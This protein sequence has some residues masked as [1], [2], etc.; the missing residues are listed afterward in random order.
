MENEK[1]IHTYFLFLILL[2]KQIIMQVSCFFQI[3]FA[4]HFSS[5]L[6][7]EEANDIKQNV[8]L[9][10]TNTTQEQ[11]VAEPLVRYRRQP[12]RPIVKY[13]SRPKRFKIKRIKRPKIKYSFAEP[14]TTYYVRKPIVFKKPT[15]ESSIYEDFSHMNVE[16]ADFDLPPSSYEAQSMELNLYKHYEPTQEASYKDIQ[17]PTSYSYTAPEVSYK[18]PLYSEIPKTPT[19]A[20][21]VPEVSFK[22]TVTYSYTPSKSLK[23]K[24]HTKYGVPTEY[25]YNTGFDNSNT[26]KP[27]YN[28]HGKNEYSFS[29]APAET[30]R[31]P[32]TKYGVPDAHI[33]LSDYNKYSLIEQKP[34]YASLSPTKT[35][36]Y[37][38]AEP[39]QPEPN[40]EI[41]Y[42]PSYEINIPSAHETSYSKGKYNVEADNY[43][44][45]QPPQQ[46]HPQNNYELS[47]Q[48]NYDQAP[49]VSYQESSDTNPPPSYQPAPPQNGNIDEY[50]PTA[51]DLPLNV[52]NKQPPYD[53]PKSSY[54]VPIYDPIPFESSNNQEQ[55]V[56]PP[57]SYDNTNRQQQQQQANNKPEFTNRINDNHNPPQKPQGTVVRPNDVELIEQ[58]QQHQN[59]IENHA[60]SP[61]T[62][63]RGIR[64]RKRTKGSSTTVS[65]TKHILDVPEL[66]EA[67]EKEKRNRNAQEPDTHASHKVENFNND[68]PWNP[69]KIRTSPIMSTTPKTT[70]TAINTR[71]IKNNRYQHRQHRTS[72][73]T[74]TTVAPTRVAIISIEKSRSKTYYD[75]TVTTPR[76]YNA[77]YFRN[78]YRLENPTTVKPQMQPPSNEMKFSK[79]TTKNVFDTTIFKS[80]INDGDVYRNL[81]KNHKP[82]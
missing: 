65:T 59:P 63:L 1:F 78:R 81:P 49:P 68:G 10:K 33:P 6:A 70:S 60:Q 31:I 19:Y 24:P 8:T 18:Q 69:M 71:T 35:E 50:I 45:Q 47:H 62:L 25:V 76:A 16:S 67:F 7:T 30:P 17:K 58:P 22:E 82:F 61:I 23:R 36:T 27:S 3:I 54:E 34:N 74:T 77:N 11:P 55:E 75:G 39:P 51:E 38:F 56:Y 2:L 80:P 53:Y 73:T 5:T 66:E 41:T 43:N 15:F 48:Q 4:L 20:Y 44:E 64:K 14:P 72:T 57:Q 21:T 13:I 40:V 32:A 37:N 42:S 29:K 79:R 46:Y 26:E 28:A 9:M 12:P 52:N